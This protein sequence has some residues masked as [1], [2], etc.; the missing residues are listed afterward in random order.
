M[1]KRKELAK[2]FM[3]TRIAKALSDNSKILDSGQID[4]KSLNPITVKILVEEDFGNTIDDIVKSF[5]EYYDQFL[6]CKLKPEDSDG[7]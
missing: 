4:P 5:E 3:A 7:V 1:S 6:T 2:Q